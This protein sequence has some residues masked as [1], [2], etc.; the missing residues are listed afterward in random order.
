MKPLLQTQTFKKI[1]YPS[2]FGFIISF[3]LASGVIAQDDPFEFVVA[4][5]LQDVTEKSAAI[6]WETS[7]PCQGAILLARAEYEILDPRMEVVAHDKGMK[8]LHRLEVK[9]LE[10]YE[11]YYYQGISINSSGDTL[12][13]PV[14]SLRVPGYH[15]SPVNFTVIGDS[16]G[17]PAVWGRIAG[18]MFKETPQFILHAGD[19]VQ[20]GPHKDDWVTEFFKPASKILGHVPLYPAIGNHEMNDPKFY[21]YF[22]LAY[23]D[24]FYSVKKGN[25]RVIMVDTN[26]DLL[27]GS[28][29]Y[30]KLESLLSETGE[31]WKIMVHHH[32]VFN[33]DMASYRSSLMAKPIQGD[34]NILH[35]KTL[36][37]NYGVDLVLAGHIHGYERTHPVYKDH[38]DPGE[39]TVHIITG[40]AGGR[41]R[42]QAAAK[43]WFSS[44]IR[45]T[46]HFLSFSIGEAHLKMEAID[47]TGR[48]FDVWEMEKR[49]GRSRLI[50][51]RIKTDRHYFLEAVQLT[52]ANPNATGNIVARVNDGGYHTASDN[53][54]TITVKETTTVSAFITDHKAGRSREVVKTFY[55]LPL[56]KKQSRVQKK[57]MAEYAE[58]HF[59][60]IPNF[61]RLASKKR[62]QVDSLSLNE[63]Q[64]RAENHFAVRFKGVFQVSET[65]VYRFLLESYD[66]SRLLIDGQEIINNDGVHYE[67][68]REGFAGL[69]KGYHE[70]E[71]Q[72]FD[73]TRRETLN[74]SMGKE[75][76]AMEDINRFLVR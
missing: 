39:G 59:T 41:L 62:F 33:S 22:H 35:L 58:G 2:I 61:D 42:F 43:N 45:K 28:V 65:A 76:A 30:K 24:A 27:P 5:Y 19:L 29:N 75:G 32:P 40:G 18:L 20:Y 14:T 71:V 13:G 25:V 47:T 15:K 31:P 1:I 55:K 74:V 64:P 50:P 48:V 11:F 57:L 73:F 38:I 44:K 21:E 72:Y 8:K 3:F 36:Y 12:K 23:D 67:I 52:F 10:P 37:D 63:I 17:N 9:G 7:Q 16:Q 26:K 68:Y 49:M 4:P 46:H 66:G 56:M 53:D 6:M 69:E 34:P 60:L 70:I 51:P 54:L